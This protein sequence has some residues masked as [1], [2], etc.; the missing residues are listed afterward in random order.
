MC[1]DS[2]CFFGIASKDKV[3][4][5]SLNDHVRRVLKGA[6]CMAPDGCYY[7]SHSLRM[8]SFNE[9]SLLDLPMDFIMRRLDWES[10][11]MLRVHLDIRLT[12]SPQ[13]HWFFGHL[14]RPP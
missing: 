6:G 12:K 8:G 7:S 3:R 11:E 13:S 5:V 14:R 9:L 1:P 4:D 10:E 2:A